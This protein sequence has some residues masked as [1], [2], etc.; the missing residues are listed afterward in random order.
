M[1]IKCTELSFLTISFFKLSL[2]NWKELKPQIK[3]LVD[4]DL[5]KD[6]IDICYSDYFKYNN[7]PPYM[8]PFIHLIE[9]ELL[10]F[11]NGA[12]MSVQTPDKWQMW[13]QTYK[14]TDSHPL[15]NHGF[16]NLSAILYLDFDKELHQPTRFW[17]PLPDP[18]FGTIKHYQP[19]VE[20]GDIVFF[21]STISHECPASNSET[22]RSI[23]AFNV[24]IADQSVQ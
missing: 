21:P 23:I 24:P 10:D 14:G 1:T 19:E 6:R 12:G 11:F 9:D 18:F 2:S 13:S 3:R 17:Q 8:I 15:H 22:Y 20:E 16:G 4:L 7:R 5:E